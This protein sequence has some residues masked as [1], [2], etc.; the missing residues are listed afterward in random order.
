MDNLI[1]RLYAVPDSYFEFVDS[2]I[3]Y[4]SSDASHY[5]L[6][7]N[8]LNNNKESTSSDILYF[9]STQPDFFDDG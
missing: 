3:D 6:I 8:Y 9:I 1:K 5:T 4:A 2:I 7:M